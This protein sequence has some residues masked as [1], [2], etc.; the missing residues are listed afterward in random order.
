MDDHA[1]ALLLG[2]MQAPGLEARYLK[3]VLPLVAEVKVGHSWAESH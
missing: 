1:A 3:G 2:V